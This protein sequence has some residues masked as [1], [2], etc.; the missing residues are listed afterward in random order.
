MVFDQGRSHH[1]PPSFSTRKFE[2]SIQATCQLRGRCT[3]RRD[4]VSR[5]DV[6]DDIGH[7]FVAVLDISW[8][9]LDAHTSTAFPASASWEDTRKPWMH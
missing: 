6:D 3:S 1:V 4:T 7:L 2:P 8:K 9:R 5:L